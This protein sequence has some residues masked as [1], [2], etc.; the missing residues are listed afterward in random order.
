MTEHLLER[1][2]LAHVR[3]VID[4]VD[5]SLLLHLAARRRLVRVV[6]TLKARVGVPARDARREQS[7]RQ[8]AMR[9]ADLLGLPGT[10]ARALLDL[11]IG[12]GCR[13]QG[14]SFDQDQCGGDAPAPTISPTMSTPS[15]NAKPSARFLRLLPPPRLAA[16]LFR[17]IPQRS[18]NA[19][20]G[21][22]MTHVL[23]VPLADGMLEFM[24]ARRLAIEVQDLGLRWVVELHDGRLRATDGT[25]DA[26][27]CGS[28]TDLLLLAGR[29]EDAD[30][31][32]FQRRLVLTGDT[33][34]GLTARN[35]LDRLPWESIPLALRIVINRGARF[36]RAARAA[37]RGEAGV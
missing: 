32:F 20:L 28:V 30:T 9:V 23:S 11:I 26:S 21:S 33:E 29:L 12:D 5:D 24:R 22:V 31:L 18:Q 7:V 1:R 37:H 36:A 34:L 13:Q 19:L 8:R 2:A 3:N 35:V 25:A 10:T 15:I 16:P 17:A 27:V 6:A 14:L 4:H